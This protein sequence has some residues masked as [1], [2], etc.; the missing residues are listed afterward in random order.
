MTDYIGNA[1]T[2]SLVA[3]RNIASSTNASPIEITTS[4][5]HGFADGEVVE[6]VGHQTNLAANRTWRIVLVSG[7]KFTL[8]GSTGTGVGGAT[9]TVRAIAPRPV[10]ALPDDSS[11]PTASTFD[12]PI[13][14]HADQ[15]A[16]L[17]ARAGALCVASTAEVIVDDDGFG[18]WST[19]GTGGAATWTENQK[20]GAGVGGHGFTEF[21][22]GAVVD[23]TYGTRDIID[24]TFDT[25]IGGLSA[26][27]DFSLFLLL[28]DYGVAPAFANATRVLGSGIE[29]PTGFAGSL[30]LRGRRRISGFARGKYAR[31]YL[32]AKDAA[33]AAS[34]AL[35]GDRQ[36]IVTV[37][38]DARVMP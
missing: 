30:H 23:V 8:T 7:T 32:A 33:G 2:V 18:S 9:G 22:A 36:L 24:V 38:R 20:N 29:L 27:I 16:S 12:P 37:K 15:I 11:P 4:V 31:V 13:E 1:G 3:A 17:S 26:V 35:Y 6:V 34:Y 21:A 19:D 5:A 10:T 14:T 25:T 28:E